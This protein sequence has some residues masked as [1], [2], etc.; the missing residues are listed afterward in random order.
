[1]IK[2]KKEPKKWNTLLIF[3]QN[4]YV[5]KYSCMLHNFENTCTQDICIINYK[6]N[7]ILRNKKKI[8]K[9][10]RTNLHIF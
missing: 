5:Y 2:A 9:V 3:Q 7:E 10:T 6:I 1:M 8:G 4:K